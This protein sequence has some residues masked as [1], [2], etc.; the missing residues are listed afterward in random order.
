MKN[1]KLYLI[2][3]ILFFASSLFSQ[4]SVSFTIG[5]PP[6]WGPYGYTNVRFYYLPDIEAYYDVQTSMFIY[7]ERGTWVHRVYLPPQ[8]KNYDLYGGYKV[9][10]PNYR[11]NKP[12]IYYKDHRN[13][14]KKGYRGQKQ[15]TNG[16][17]PGKG[18]NG[19]KTYKNTN[20]GNSKKSQGNGNGQNQSKG[21]SKGNGKKRN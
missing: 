7:L 2:A 9:V 21:K 6:P 10:M 19:N 4:V 14:F 18:N 16:M 3:T 1:I 20:K 17:K 12:Y 8:Y 15:K 11:G 5:T 13:K